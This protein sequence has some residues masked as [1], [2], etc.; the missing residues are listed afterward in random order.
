MAELT[1][2]ESKLAEVIGLA[3]AAQG[4][5]ERVEGLLED[6]PEIAERLQLPADQV[7]SHLSG[8]LRELRERLA[9]LH[10]AH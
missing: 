6:Q 7:R 1:N 5:T 2:I 8:S 3:Q 9:V 10:D 4:A